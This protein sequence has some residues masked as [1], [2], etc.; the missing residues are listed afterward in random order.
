MPDKRQKEKF[1]IQLLIII[2][3]VTK[4]E[5][6]QKVS[7]RCYCGAIAVTHEVTE[8][9][10]TV[11]TQGLKAR[12]WGAAPVTSQANQNWAQSPCT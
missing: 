5:F 12:Q 1:L 6:R 3:G 7:C 8:V 10:E 4:N 2:F 11:V 9:S